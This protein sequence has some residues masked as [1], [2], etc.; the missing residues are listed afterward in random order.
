MVISLSSTHD[1]CQSDEMS[2][3]LLQYAPMATEAQNSIVVGFTT[4][5]TTM[6][7]RADVSRQPAKQ[8][9]CHCCHPRQVVAGKR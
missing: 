4:T 5:F 8:A 2:I 1:Q 3:T 7:G 9:A 6:A